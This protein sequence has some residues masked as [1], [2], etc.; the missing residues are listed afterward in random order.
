MSF[1]VNFMAA[2]AADIAESAINEPIK[3]AVTVAGGYLISKVVPYVSDVC[4]RF[5]KQRAELRRQQD[6]ALRDH[7]YDLRLQVNYEL[8]DACVNK[9]II[10]FREA[11]PLIRHDEE[12]ARIHRVW[13]E[14]GL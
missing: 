9:G 6:P 7:Q 10:G 13:R 3:T 2:A 8:T 11:N 14:A 12:I 5:M 4:S 1:V